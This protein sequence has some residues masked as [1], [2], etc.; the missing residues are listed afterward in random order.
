LRAEIAADLATIALCGNVFDRRRK[1]N[2]RQD[3]IERT[4]ATI[5]AGSTKGK[6][7]RLVEIELVDLS[8]SDEGFADCPVP[9]LTYNLHLFHEFAD[10]RTA[11]N[12]IPIATLPNYC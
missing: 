12:R 3:F 9:A 6:E 11:D 2:S 4:Q 7:V 5:G 1:F 8:D 10:T